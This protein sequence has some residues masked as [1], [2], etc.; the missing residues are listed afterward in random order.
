VKIRTTLIGGQKKMLVW[1]DIVADEKIR[2]YDKGVQISSGDGIRDLLVNY[3]SGDMWAPQIEQL[4]ALRVELGYF[5]DCIMK[6]EIP[7]NDGHA[8]L[9]VVR[10]LEAAD[11]SIQKRGELVRL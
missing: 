6:N 7:F 2:V 4:E 5:A 10:M 1:N 3:R 8:G 9:R 11:R